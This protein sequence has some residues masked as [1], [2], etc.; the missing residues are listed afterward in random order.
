MLLKLGHT[1]GT[2]DEDEK[3]IIGLS[4]S[5]KRYEVHLYSSVLVMTGR[6]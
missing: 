2:I 6:C 5:S 4:G 1:L 3:S